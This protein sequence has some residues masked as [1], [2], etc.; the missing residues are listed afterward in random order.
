MSPLERLKRAAAAKGHAAEQ[1]RKALREAHQA[2]HSYA[3]I[4]R[5]LDITRQ[6][7]RGALVTARIDRFDREE[8][9]P[10]DARTSRGA[11]LRKKRFGMQAN[12]TDVTHNE[13]SGG[14]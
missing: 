13:P 3:E 14:D 11:A 2:G 8:K 5:A 10:D 9:S 12:L 6:A 4:G 1:Y 7:V